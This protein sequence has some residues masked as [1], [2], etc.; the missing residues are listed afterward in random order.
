M[1]F[2]TFLEGNAVRFLPLADYARECG[3]T[4]NQALRQVIAR[5]IDAQKLGGHWFV[6]VPAEPPVAA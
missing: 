6:L 4:Y 2:P 5:E 3:L 1:L